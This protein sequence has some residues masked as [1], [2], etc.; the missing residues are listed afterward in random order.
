M[1]TFDIRFAKSV[2]L[3]GLFEVPANQLGWKGSGRLSID[4]QRISIAVKRGL[5]TLFSR[6]TRHFSADS[7]T[8]AYR[9]GD[10]LRLVFGT[11]EQPEVLS[12]WARGGEA[13]AEIVKLLPTLRTVELDHSTDGARRYRFD[14]KA[15]LL[16]LALAVVAAAGISMALRGFGVALP[17]ISSGPD[18]PTSTS[19]EQSQADGVGNE[20]AN[21]RARAE[22]AEVSTR[23]RSPGA[24]TVAQ[25][26]QVTGKRD[27]QPAISATTANDGVE[28]ASGST[29]IPRAEI[30]SYAY[31]GNEID[32]LRQE[33]R[34]LRGATS[35]AVLAALEERWWQMTVRIYLST[36]GADYRP[37]ACDVLA[38]SRA[39]R[40]HLYFYAESLRTGDQS[41]MTLATGQLELAEELQRSIEA[42]P[43]SN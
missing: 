25:S 23:S 24:A 22:A 29:D 13:A 36:S 26:S 14:W 28:G 32:S 20:V 2:G 43:P 31:Y 11:R 17:G 6:P 41:L 38:L 40:N 10:A 37:G 8:E 21:P 35:A 19:S 30:L 5:L 27:D 42:T 9:E 4:G 34:D 18:S 12:V 1:H 15:A 33:Y 7:L 16:L 3:A 39:W